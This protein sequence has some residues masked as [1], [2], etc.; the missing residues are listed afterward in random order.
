MSLCPV[1][2]SIAAPCFTHHQTLLPSFLV[3]VT[4][5]INK[6]EETTA[7]LSTWSWAAEAEQGK[8]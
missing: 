2:W 5:Y 6:V 3:A 7:H 8:S 1:L 4:V